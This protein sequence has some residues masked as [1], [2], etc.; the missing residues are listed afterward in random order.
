[1]KVTKKNIGTILLFLVPGFLVYAYLVLYPILQS[2][3]MSTYTWD[4]L[5]SSRFVGFN[6]YRAVLGSQMFWKV[7]GNTLIF[8]VSTT[9]LQVLIGF[10]LGYLIYLQLKGYRLY[11]TLYFIPTVLP[12]VAVGF[13]WNYIYSPGMG[14][15][16]PLMNAVGAG[17]HYIPPLS[18]PQLALIAI[19]IAQTWNS[20]G[21]QVILFNSGF[22]NM[23]SEVIESATLDGATGWKMI[24]HMVIPLSWDIIKMVIIL[25]TVGALRSFDLVYVMTGGGPNHATELL[26]LH[27]FVNAFQNFNIGYGNVMAV[28]IFVLAM[29][30]TVVMRKL[31]ERESL[32]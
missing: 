14:L 23:S 26:P 1:M 19:I 30:I 28:L 4:T 7:L 27:L 31:M 6:N 5:A 21:I 17:A 8:M 24:R 22:M 9:T 25:Q 32:Y 2:V 20:C 3:V 12:S 11:K 15:L 13:I 16:K 18:S 10:L 29:T